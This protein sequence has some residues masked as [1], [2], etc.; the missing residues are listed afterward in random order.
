MTRTVDCFPDTCRG[1]GKALRHT[2]DASPH[3]HQFIDIPLVA[4]DVTAFRQHHV[5][6]ACGVTTCGALPSG[7]PMGLLGLRLLAPVV[8]LTASCH[9]S[10]RKKCRR[11]CAT[12]STSTSRRA[13]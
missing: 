1:C 3:R 7:A 4:P 5:T 6:C 8:I 2:P 13:R 12:S 11:C 9:V 10:R